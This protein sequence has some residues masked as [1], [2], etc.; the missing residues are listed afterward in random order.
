MATPVSNVTHLEHT[1]SQI[2][3]SLQIIPNY[4]GSPNQLHRFIT[5][6]E[7]ILTQ[8]YDAETP[9]CFNNSLI[10]HSI[11]NKLQGKAEEIVNINGVTS[12]EQLKF[13]LLKNF[14]DQRDENCLNR[15]LV[16]MKQENESPQEY[17]NRCI[18]ILNTITNYI[19]LHETNEAVIICKREFFQAQ[20]LKTFLAGLKEPLGTTIRA[21]RPPDLATALNYIKEEQNIQ[22]IR[23][24]NNPQFYTK[25][26]Q[27]KPNLNFSNNSKW[28]LPNL[29][30]PLQPQKQ[31]SMYQN[32]FTSPYFQRNNN[33]RPQNQS[34]QKPNYNLN[35]F[36]QPQFRPYLPNNNFNNNLV[37]KPQPMSGLSYSSANIPLKPLLNNYHSTQCPD[38]VYQYGETQSHNCYGSGAHAQYSGE[39]YETDNDVAQVGE[40]D[41]SNYVEQIEPE[42]Q[43]DSQNETQNFCQ[44]SN[45]GPCT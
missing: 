15:D 43:S 34:F 19:Q 24:N 23:K 6:C 9:N 12:W 30:R 8:Y 32:R 41:D 35:R 36:Q 22:Y 40:L 1:L 17:Y 11:L 10:L 25:P 45:P 38:N 42:R 13:V 14:G 29:N 3:S 20:T 27:N 37:P 33:F 39:P 28:P 2:K 21:M 16:N 4:D 7:T 44:D 18:H 5:T 31:N 26:D